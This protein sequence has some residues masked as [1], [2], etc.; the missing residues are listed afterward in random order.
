M[1]SPR[2]WALYL[3]LGA[4]TCSMLLL[5]QFLTRIFSV[6][7]TSGLA[8]LALSITFLGLGSA[9]WMRGG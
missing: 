2:P 7:F 5:Q 6:L 8:F 4:T 9:G 1:I 3:G